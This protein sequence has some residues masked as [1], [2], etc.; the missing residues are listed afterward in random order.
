MPVV[1]LARIIIKISISIRLCQLKVSQCVNIYH[2]AVNIMSALKQFYLVLQARL[3]HWE[4][5]QFP[6]QC[7]AGFVPHLERAQVSPLPSRASIYLQFSLCS[8]PFSGSFLPSFLS[9]CLN[10]S[11]SAEWDIR[12]VLFKLIRLV[13]LWVIATEVELRGRQAARLH[14]MTLPTIHGA[15]I[16]VLAEVLT[17]HHASFLP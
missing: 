1:S 9:C 10:F 13:F 11:Y 7:Q 15:P 4:V 6:V 5:Y 14:L 8:A 12:C 2:Q 16:R 17:Q 3:A